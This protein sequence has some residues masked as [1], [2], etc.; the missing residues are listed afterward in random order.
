MRR[1]FQLANISIERNEIVGQEFVERV[2]AATELPPHSAQGSQDRNEGGKCCPVH[3]SAIP[4]GRS[5]RYSCNP[6]LFGLG[7]GRGEIVR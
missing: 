7:I 1:A 6:L 3:V 5:L 4:Q 2:N